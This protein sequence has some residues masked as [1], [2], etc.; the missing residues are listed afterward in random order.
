MDPNHIN[1]PPARVPPSSPPSS[2]KK[3]R[4]SLTIS[5]PVAQII[6][7]ACVIAAVIGFR[8]FGGD[9]YQ[10]FR[11][12]YVQTMSDSIT[13]DAVTGQ[14]REWGKSMPVFDFLSDGIQS[15]FSPVEEESAPASSGPGASEAPPSSV[16]EASQGDSS[17]PDDSSHLPDIFSD[18][19]DSADL[20]QS[21]AS[22]PLLTLSAGESPSVQ[23]LAHSGGDGDAFPVSLFGETLSYPP[24]YAS[25]APYFLT[26]PAAL[27]LT[28]GRVTSPFGYRYY[29]SPDQQSFHRGLDIGAEEGQDIYS[30]LPGTVEECGYMED[31]YGNYVVIRHSG[32]TQTLYAHCSKLL[33]KDG[34]V[35]RQGE[36]IAQVGSTGN[37]T[38][39][40]LHLELR[41]N[42]LTMDPSIALNGAY[43]P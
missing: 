6:V 2:P 13:L 17:L 19:L 21:D 35:V 37:S 41:I 18:G 34:A 43:A 27:P 7:C 12:S 31:G 1:R 29:P 10:E 15:V 3:D 20:A 22:L 28:A 42:G 9:N 30:I 14:L 26:V 23:T 38:G 40:H 39:P 16:P 8:S 36:R 5:L 32:G 33:V 25:F 4:P 11:Q 24:D